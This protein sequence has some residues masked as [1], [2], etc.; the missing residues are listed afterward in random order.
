MAAIKEFREPIENKNVERAWVREVKALQRVCQLRL[1]HVVDIAAMI[2]IGKK[3][4][5]VFP[6]ADGGNLLNFWESR[7]SYHDRS[8]IATRHIPD[9]VN[10]LVGLAGALA[11]LHNFTQGKSGG[12][13]HGNLTPE[14]ILVFDSKSHNS[15]G[16]WKIAGLGLGKYHMIASGDRVYVTSNSRAGTISYQPPESLTA[17]V[18]P[19]SRRYDIWFMGCII[20]QL[21]T[22]LLYGTRKID[23]LTRNAQSVIAKGESSYWTASWNERRGYHNIRI[24]SSVRS[25]MAQMK[26][27]S[28][29]SR[30]LRD[31]LSIVENK[32]LV[33]QLPRKAAIPEW[34]RRT[35]S[36]DLHESLKRIQAACK[37]Q[38]YWFPGGNIVKQAIHPKTPQGQ[39]SGA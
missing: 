22:W 34:G 13:R 37:D 6:W 28:Q 1:L 18:A 16:I 14:N 4:Y 3:Q 27:D 7:D 25:H 11:R 38:R 9:I 32:L 8:V 24:H 33:V 20:L 30:A 29:G 39:S 5:C 36:A 21:L 17:K 35:N 31:L 19:T 26:H 2:V 12:Y 23:E 10:Q 15:L